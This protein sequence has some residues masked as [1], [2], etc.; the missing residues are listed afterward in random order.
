VELATEDY[1]AIQQLYAR[2]A[3]SVDTGDR[4]GWLAC[5]IEDGALETSTGQLNQ[6]PEALRRMIDTQLSS[7]NEK[8]YH[9]N[10]NL[11]IEPAEFGATGKTY[12]MFVRALTIEGELGYSL[13]Y[14]DELVKQDGRW[15]FRKRKL[16]R[17]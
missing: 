11:V 6:G 10:G 9:W 16:N 13:Y 8:G 5:W 1:I 14:T 12:L 15:L 2:Y 4:D 7:P 3:F 17:V